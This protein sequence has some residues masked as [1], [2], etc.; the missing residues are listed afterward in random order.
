MTSLEDRYGSILLD[1]RQRWCWSRV[2]DD[3]LLTASALA[4]SRHLARLWPIARAV[5]SCLEVV[6]RMGQP[7]AFPA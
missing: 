6:S 7:A 4:S 5:T 2:F 1:V 3:P